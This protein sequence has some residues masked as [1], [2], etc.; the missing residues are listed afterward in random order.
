MHLTLAVKRVTNLR[1]HTKIK[2]Y[3]TSEFV[4]KNNQLKV[5]LLKLYIYY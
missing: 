2:F 4:N 5:A 1:I 3:V